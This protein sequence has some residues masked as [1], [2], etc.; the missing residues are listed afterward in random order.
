VELRVGDFVGVVGMVSLGS[1]AE[2][3]VGPG[4]LA[5]EMKVD[6]G[7]DGVIVGRIEAPAGAL[8]HMK[9]V[10]HSVAAVAVEHVVVQAGLEEAEVVVT[11]KLVAEVVG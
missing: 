8:T 10:A 4:Q 11:A 3:Y 5:V 7:L 1:A 6:I 9:V 2:I